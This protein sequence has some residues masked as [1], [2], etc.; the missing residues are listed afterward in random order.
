L[1]IS[2]AIHC[3]VC[4]S[5]YIV[6]HRSFGGDAGCAA[7]SSLCGEGGELVP[8]LLVMLNPTA[9]IFFGIFNETYW[10]GL[11]RKLPR[12]GAPAI[13]FVA[14]DA[15]AECGGSTCAICLEEFSSGCLLGRLPCGH[16]YHMNCLRKWLST[17]RS[18]NWCPMRCPSTASVSREV[19]PSTIGRV[20]VPQVP[21]CQS[22]SQASRSG[23]DMGVPV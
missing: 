1:I 20:T 11:T 8:E 4:L 3:G 22:T 16:I 10:S 19:Y 23:L 17:V 2:A 21:K 12:H 9:T 14:H 18:E 15:L 6:F 5:I 13:E 7:P